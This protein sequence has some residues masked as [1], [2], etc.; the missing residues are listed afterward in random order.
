MVEDKTDKMIGKI[1]AMLDKAA[2]TTHEAEADAFYAKAGALMA[3][4]RISDEDLT[5]A[6]AAEIVTKH[7]MVDNI[8]GRKARYGRARMSLLYVIA[9]AN[10]VFLYGEYGYGKKTPDSAVMIG[11]E[12]SITVVLNLF[13]LLAMEADRAALAYTSTSHLSAAEIA[14]A[15]MM[16]VDAPKLSPNELITRRRSVW[17]GFANRIRERLTEGIAEADKDAG[18]GLLPVLKSDFEKA[19]EM[20]PKLSTVS[21]M[22][23][24]GAAMGVGAAA[25]GAADIGRG[26]VG[27]SRPALGAG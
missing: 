10:G 25:A 19:A 21:G 27:G 8:F 7:F 18:G 15:D 9:K 26:R 14:M 4:H 17:I 13:A 11:R 12:D 16:G 22:T 3:A 2:S 23:V 24:D 6:E 1:K 5:A 20:A